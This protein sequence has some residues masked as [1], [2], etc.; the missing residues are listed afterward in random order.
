MWSLSACG[1]V[2]KDMV[3]GHYKG[4]L[5]LSPALLICDTLCDVFIFTISIFDPIQIHQLLENLYMTALLIDQTC[6]STAEY[7]VEQRFL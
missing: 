4:V 5:F 3:A 2:L 6:I 1:C 7:S